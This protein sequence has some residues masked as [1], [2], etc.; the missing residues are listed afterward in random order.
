[1]DQIKQN[2][3]QFGNQ[4]RNGENTKFIFF[5]ILFF[6]VL[7]IFIYSI[8]TQSQMKNKECSYM[9]QLYPS[10]NSHIKS[11][12]SNDEQC[13][14]K[15]FDYY[16]KTAYNACSGGNYKNDFVDVCNLKA[17]IKEGVRCIDLEIYNVNDEPVIATSTVDDYYIKETYNYVMFSEVMKTIKNYAFSSGTCPN[18]ED[19]LLLHLRIKSSNQSTFSK[20]ADILKSYSD[21]LLGNSY[22]YDNEGYNIGLKPLLSFKKKV[23]IITDKSNP[24]YLEN[25]SFME[26][27]NLTSSSFFMREYRYDQV[28]HIPDM[29]ELQEYNKKSMTIVLPNLENN[30]K[31]PNGILCREMGCQMVAMRYQTIDSHMEEN[32]VFFNQ[33]GYAF[34]LKPERLRYIPVVIPEPEKQN[35]NYSYETREVK[36]DFYQFKF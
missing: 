19:P 34:A 3:I 16:I 10:V 28:K 15:L 23:I 25:Q 12:Q 9:E 20:M 13:K 35:P 30:P 33:C 32:A 27:V 17:V 22:S 7:F 31:N 2:I 36:S 26:Y 6:I 11:I 8:I 24:G 29:D 5:S 14:M 1:M 21:L 4:I 18:F